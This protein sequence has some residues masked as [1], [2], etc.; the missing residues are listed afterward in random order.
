MQDPLGALVPGN[1]VTLDGAADGP[2][3]GRSFVAKDLF[4]VAGHV[5]GCGNPD[6]A[7]THAAAS[8]N[9]WAVEAW[10]QAGAALVGKAITDEL[11][12]SLNGENFHYGTPTNANAPG[13]IPGG[14]SAGS[15]S[16]VAG[17]LCDIALGTDTGGSVRV[18]GSYCGDFGFRPSHGRISLDGAMALAPSMDTC[19][20]FARDVALFVTAGEVLL[21]EKVAAAAQPTRLILF[22]DAFALADG[23]ARD[24]LMPFVAQLEGRLGAAERVAAGEPGGGLGEWM[25]R[26]RQLQ[27]REVW[28]VHGDWIES[29]KPRFGPDIGERF[30]WASTITAEQAAQAAPERAAITERL[31]DM[32]GDDAVACLPSAPGAAPVIGMTGEALQQR[33]ANVMGL[34]CL[35]PL[36]G[37][38]QMTLPLATVEG[39]PLGLSLM[40]G[41]GRDAE[42]LALAQAWLG[43]KSL[44]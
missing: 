14:S 43:E 13:R 17:G 24:A 22:E 33:R 10:L 18:P 44:D 25:W 19:G 6:W 26:F 39:C 9:A 30:Q 41:P 32:L 15:A 21:Q 27:G 5:T 12:Y 36:T 37:L 34:S 40:A 28:S 11:A 42:L 16:A 29:V 35:A 1:D 23:P 31:S 3:K 38:P 7:R 2:L 20:W 8:T 4:D